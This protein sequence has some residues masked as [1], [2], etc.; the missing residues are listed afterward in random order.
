MDSTKGK[1]VFRRNGY[2]KTIKIKTNENKKLQDKINNDKEEKVKTHFKALSTYVI[3]E[4]NLEKPRT[5]FNINFSKNTNIFTKVNNL[6]LKKY[7]N[8]ALE[9]NNS[10]TDAS[11]H[12]IKFHKINR[13]SNISHDEIERLAEI[14]INNIKAK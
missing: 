14:Q 7:D 2:Y 3:S 6:R 12:T 4:T 5:T 11:S 1:V 8:R 13:T 9:D 10:K